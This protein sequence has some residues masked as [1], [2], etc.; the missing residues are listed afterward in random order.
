MKKA[1]HLA[2]VLALMTT[3]L[4]AYPEGDCYVHSCSDGTYIVVTRSDWKGHT[5]SA[6][7]LE[8]FVGKN[9]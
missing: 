9:C 8:Q 2:F 7:R 4:F 6:A 3:S 1:I 5:I